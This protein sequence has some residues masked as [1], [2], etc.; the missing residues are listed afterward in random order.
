MQTPE[1]ASTLNKQIPEEIGRLR[2]PAYLNAVAWS[3]DGSRLAGLSNYGQ[4]ITVWDTKTWTRVNEFRNPGTMYM[5]NS[6]EFLADGSILTT[7][8]VV[9]GK[10]H[11]CSLVQW[12]PD[13][14]ERVREIPEVCYPDRTDDVGGITET[15]SVSKDGALIVGVGGKVG[16]ML[17]DAHSGQFIKT[18]RVPPTPFNPDTPRSAA[19]SPDGQ[20]LAI[21]TIFGYL[22]FFEIR[23]GRLTKTINVYDNEAGY[24]S[25]LA[26]NP[27]GTLIAASKCKGH[28]MPN[29]IDSAATI[30]R[31]TDGAQV[32]ILPGST[33]K[34]HDGKDEAASARTISWS[35]KGDVLAVGDDLA[36]KLWQVDDPANPKL[37]LDKRIDR[38]SFKTAFSAQGLLAA[39]DNNEIMIFK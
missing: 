17:F 15:Y 16:V 35:P 4:T 38:G 24:I 37:L 28:D 13:K 12:N 3:F 9:F 5:N 32:S 7:P 20:L 1:P 11:L 8:K 30:W 36:L 33:T 21:G 25:G 27:D 6:L 19:F 31:V 39:T 18:F 29:P 2:A 22:H 26:F 34:R 23:S 10:V 14:G